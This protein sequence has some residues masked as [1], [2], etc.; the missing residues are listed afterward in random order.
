MQVP[1]QAFPVIS[2]LGVV[3]QLGGAVMLIGLFALLRGFV[4][5]R[6]YFAVWTNA[7]VAIAVAILALVIRYILIP[8]AVGVLDEGRPVV[9]LLYFIYQFSKAF[10]F[11]FFL[12]GTLL[13]AAGSRNKI[14]LTQHLWFG[15]ALFA[16]V[17]TLA[18]RQGLNEMVIWQSAVAVPALTYCAWTLLKLPRARRTVGTRSTGAAFGAL[19]ALWLLYAFA[20]GIIVSGD[21]ASAVG[22]LAD[23]FVGFNTYYDLAFDFLLGYAMVI[24]LME[25]SR[26]EVDD[27]QA[28]LR[29]THDQLR[30]AALYDTLTDSLNRRAY[31]ERVGMEMVRATFGTIVLADLDNLKTVNDRLG[32][33]AGDLLLRQCADVLRGG[34]RP[35][36][37]LYRWGGDEFLIIVPS[38]RAEDV[39][40]RLQ[41][42][43]SAAGV[44]RV[45]QGADIHLEVS[46]GAAD[47][48]S[49]DELERAIDRADRAMYAEKAR[50]KSD[51]RGLRKSAVPQQVLA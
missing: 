51:P 48:E 49:F 31:V 30:R 16:L 28:E 42:S 32:H 26:R 47:Y 18:S 14:V 33:G 2:F 35:Y 29:V 11:I 45:G 12:R 7:W 17:S 21:T 24:L 38:A 39:L 19:A 6:P 22:R 1:L 4:L 27:A 44:L 34:L 23:G 5:R 25:D 20:F 50:R 8:A 3:V 46:L 10:S 9:R 13:Y 15:A 43:V 36:D 37:K 40:R 41:E